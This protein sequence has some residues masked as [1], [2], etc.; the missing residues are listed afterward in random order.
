MQEKTYSYQKWNLEISLLGITCQLEA[1]D[2]YL[3]INEIKNIELKK[4]ISSEQLIITTYN[5]TIILHNS[6]DIDTNHIIKRFKEYSE[7][8]ITLKQEL[9]KLKTWY[10]NLLTEFDK[11]I[12]SDYWIIS[13]K[14]NEIKNLIKQKPKYLAKKYS[15]EDFIKL[16]ETYVTSDDFKKIADTYLKNYKQIRKDYL[17][18]VYQKELLD[19]KKFFDSVESKP[20]TKEQRYAVINLNDR[21]LVNASAG[22]GKTSVMV[23]K[24][25]YLIKNKLY[26]PNEILML[27]FNKSTTI[28]LKNRISQ[29]LYA[30]NIELQ[31]KDINVYTFHGFSYLILRN[32]SY[33]NK[34]ITGEFKN[35]DNKKFFQIAIEKYLNFRMFYYFFSFLHHYTKDT[36]PKINIFKYFAENFILN[37][38]QYNSKSS[39]FKEDFKEL[40]SI[41]SSLIKY[42]FI[43]D[44]LL[45]ENFSNELITFKFK[46][47]QQKEVAILIHSDQK[48]Q[49]NKTSSKSNK[50]L[51]N[52][53]EN[54][55]LSNNTS[56]Q[57]NLVFRDFKKPNI[58]IKIYK[59]LKNKEV[60]SLK[61]T[62]DKEFT[63]LEHN[64]INEIIEK[65]T[66]KHEFIQSYQQIIKNIG[67]ITWDSLY[68]YQLIHF[69][70][71]FE[72][73]YK[74]ILNKISFPELISSSIKLLNHQKQYLPFKF[75]MVDEAQDMSPLRANLIK[76]LLKK[77][78]S[79]I[80]AVGDDWQSINLFAGS[81][82]EY[83]TNFANHFG[84]CDIL[85]LSEGFRCNPDITK[86]AS[87]FIQKNPHQLRKKPFSHQ[88]KHHNPI[89]CYALTD[90][91]HMPLAIYILC[92]QIIEQ[93]SKQ[94]QCQN[95][96]S[97][98]ILGRYNAIK[99]A[100][101]FA[102]TLCNQNINIKFTT[103][104]S[105]KGLEAD[106]I[107]L[108]YMLNK[109]LPFPANMS[110]QEDVKYFYTSSDDYPD[111]E[112][113][114]L[115]Y[116]ALTRAKKQ[117]FLIT[118]KKSKSCF[119]EELIYDLKLNEK[120]LD[121]SAYTIERCPYCASSFNSGKLT[122]IVNSKNEEIMSCS[123]PYCLSYYNK[124][125]EKTTT[126][127][128]K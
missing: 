113:R 120:N 31:P 59:F 48:T 11:W 45:F 69:A 102:L 94:N 108:P 32:F 86:Y 54:I 68:N 92:K 64:L 3:K 27:A 97:I 30:I 118:N 126:I 79:K 19:N 16:I 24:Y 78:T 60:L 109:Q 34:I 21:T 5:E 65:F 61:H 43:E 29:R 104:H 17:E 66:L 51:N 37:D 40:Y 57:L 125:K 99:Q 13:A 25:V 33:R 119:Y 103:I 62:K 100:S 83:M 116:V 89:E 1:E 122:S 10:N 58:F 7:E 18:F 47:E 85:N 42:I 12:K 44:I 73:T 36:L 88:E 105:A 124:K 74:Q 46:T 8:I 106:Y 84:A 52:K 76:T 41:L 75:I 121:M 20:L 35:A 87:K 9:I 123:N 14:E 96:I 2:I 38:Q 4:S 55:Q 28:E 71:F 110:A 23:A 81:V 53:N 56:E 90:E 50:N 77:P 26:K 80:L 67:S 70:S 112:E 72:K 95:R 39:N 22:S 127:E 49:K 82:I 114:R 6:N 93:V 98:M 117:I 115:F 101:L 128:S 15:K 111:S 63:E 107:I 91:Q